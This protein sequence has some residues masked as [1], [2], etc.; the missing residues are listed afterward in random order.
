MN[1]AL[2][3]FDGTITMAD[4]F[5]PF[6]YFTASRLRLALGTAMLAPM[7]AGYELG[8]IHGSRMRA[9]AAWVAFRG[10]RESEINELGERYSERLDALVRPEVLSKLRWHQTNGDTVVVVSASLG[11]YLDGWCRRAGVERISTELEAEA[12]V[13]TGRYTL[14]DCTGPEKARRVRQRYELARYPTIYAYGD[15]AEDEDLLSLGTRRFL[16][17][18]ELEG[19]PSVLN[20]R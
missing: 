3:D 10:R 9:A 7:I 5:K 4:S 12:G 14:G 13:L 15:T 1:L 20:D 16:R 11:A 18:H 8:L 2:F 19:A 6:L 17:G